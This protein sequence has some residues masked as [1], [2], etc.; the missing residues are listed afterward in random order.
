MN[1]MMY[2]VALMA[3]AL[4][5]EDT[6]APEVA[7]PVAPEVAPEAAAVEAAP[8]TITERAAARALA[9]LRELLELDLDAQAAESGL[10]ATAE[11]G[12]LAGSDEAVGLTARALFESGREAEAEEL[13][14]T[15][16]SATDSDGWLLVERARFAL[17]RDELE[18]VE[19]LVAAP[20]GSVPPVV[21]PER[22]ETWLFLARARARG[23]DLDAAGPLAYAFTQR[24][25]LHEEAAAAWNLVALL[26]D[27]RGNTADATEA[28]RRGDELRLWHSVLRARRIQV[29]ENPGEPEPRLG[30]ALAWMEARQLGYARRTL[31]ELTQL[32]PTYARGWYH[33]G[34]VERVS[35]DLDAARRAW[36]AAL[37]ADPEQH[38][39]RFNRAWLDT[40]RGDLALAQKDWELLVASEAGTDPLFVAAHLQ[41]A[42]ILAVRGDYGASEQRYATYRELGGTDPLDPAK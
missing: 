8:Q 26:S 23:G 34:E 31:L 17:V 9:G 28:R 3:L 37:A 12:L 40:Q 4:Q 30:V 35:G 5:G 11:G 38:K 42:R 20:A 15:R 36:T 24:A 25:P 32:F 2:L 14:V 19:A 18:Q 7:P 16:G 13:L 1:S 39:A 27:E 33:L 6:P 10:A 21:H 29:R 22:P 41:L